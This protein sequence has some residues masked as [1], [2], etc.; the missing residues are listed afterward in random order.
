MNQ[1][2]P[3][4][5][6]W[7]H[8]SAEHG[9]QQCSSASAG[10]YGLAALLHDHFF[11]YSI[12]MSTAAEEVRGTW[13]HCR[14]LCCVSSMSSVRDYNVKPVQAALCSARIIH[15]DRS[16]GV[17]LARLAASLVGFRVSAICSCSQLRAEYV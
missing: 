2:Q 15:C 9:F 13:T 11:A 1:C 6:A 17:T 12:D 5:A 3:A 8:S 16:Q 10:V 14:L 4:R 7:V